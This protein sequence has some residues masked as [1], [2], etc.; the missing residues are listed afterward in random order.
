MKKYVLVAVIVV[1][2]LLVTGL[3]GCLVDDIINPI[4]VIDYYEDRSDSIGGIYDHYVKAQTFAASAT[5]EVDRI[6]VALS[7]K[8]DNGVITLQLKQNGLN[9]DILAEVF[10]DDVIMTTDSDDIFWISFDISNYGV[11]LTEGENYH[12]VLSSTGYKVYWRYVGGQPKY[13]TGSFHYSNDGGYSWDQYGDQG[14]DGLFRV[15]GRKV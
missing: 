14:D 8:G 11:V 4:E 2:T 6:E 12:I 10:K 13:A 3:S 15:Y 1:M 9:G 5:Y 7:S